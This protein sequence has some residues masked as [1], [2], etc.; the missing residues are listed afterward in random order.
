M[1]TITHTFV[2]PVVDAG[3]PNKVGPDEWNATHTITGTFPP[4]VTAQ[5]YNRIVNGAMQISQENG[6]ASMTLVNSYPADQFSL[7][8]STSGTFTIQRVQVVTPNGSRDRI[9]LT[10]STADT[11]IAAGDYLGFTTS[12]EGFRIADFLYGTA[13]AKQVILRFGF[14]APA[15]TY[16]A[17]F[18]NS[19]YNRSY[20]A[21]FTISAGQANTDTEQ[22]FVILGDV[23]G[24][25]LSDSGKGVEIFVAL[26]AG[27][28]FQGAAGWSAGG[29]IGTSTTSNGMATAGNVFE[30]WDV[31][32]YLDPQNSGV[33]PRWTMPDYAQEHES[34]RRYWQANGL[35]YSANV[36]SGSVYYTRTGFPTP[37]GPPG[38]RAGRRA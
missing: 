30:L 19:A 35:I 4:D 37:T 5:S 27:T 28:T 6:N 26:A 9:R 34:C 23:T 21:N 33:A 36:T 25:W 16:T 11:S 2:S 12:I 24:T 7:S 22:T 1:G 13:S 10:V 17:S 32:L 3:D 20:L 29:F 14:K 8:W 15:G 31:G 38:R 18:R